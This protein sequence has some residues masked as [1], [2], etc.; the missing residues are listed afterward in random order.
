VLYLTI[1][2]NLIRN[3]KPFSLIY[4]LIVIDKEFKGNSILLVILNNNKIKYKVIL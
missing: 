2:L 4:F 3:K 1:I